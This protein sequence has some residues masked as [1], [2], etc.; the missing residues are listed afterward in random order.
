MQLQDFRQLLL[1]PGTLIGLYGDDGK[2][3]WAELA[4]VKCILKSYVV[5]ERH[6]NFD[7]GQNEIQWDAGAIVS[8]L[9]PIRV[10]GYDSQEYFGGELLLIQRGDYSIRWD[11]HDPNVHVFGIRGELP[12]TMPVP[13]SLWQPKTVWLACASIMTVEEPTMRSEFS[14]FLQKRAQND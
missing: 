12:V 13:R 6:H 14:K 10:N 5:V 3:A 8:T 1:K 4:L 7:A 11:N 2:S 9:N